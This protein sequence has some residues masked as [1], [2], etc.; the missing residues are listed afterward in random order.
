MPYMAVNIPGLAAVSAP[1]YA[2]SVAA[3]ADQSSAF[4]AGETAPGER[5]SPSAFLKKGKDL[6][7]R[8]AGAFNE[9]SRSR[10]GVDLRAL[11]PKS[12]AAVGVSDAVVAGGMAMSAEGEDEKVSL[13][14]ASTP[15]SPDPAPGPGEKSLF[16]KILGYYFDTPV[17]SMT[18]MGLT[19]FAVLASALHY[20]VS[21]I[22]AH[23]DPSIEPQFV[24]HEAH[25]IAK[26]GAMIVGLATILFGENAFPKFMRPAVR[27]FLRLA[28]FAGPPL[29]F[30]GR[31]LTFG[32]K[33]KSTSDAKADE[34]ARTQ[35]T[36]MERAAEVAS[37]P[38]EMLSFVGET[39]EDPK[40]RDNGFILGAAQEIRRRYDR[41]IFDHPYLGSY[42][43]A[44]LRIWGSELVINGLYVYPLVA[45][46]LGIPFFETVGPALGISL[47]ATLSTSRMTKIW[48]ETA[49]Y[50][51]RIVVGRTAIFSF[52]NTIS[53]L[54]AILLK[55]GTMSAAGGFL[56]QFGL[57][58]AMSLAAL[59]LI[60]PPRDK[61]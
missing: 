41:P 6:A 4:A 32:K 23:S 35:A 46:S 49:E 44:D 19:E 37:L 31:L 61:K 48:G 1:L 50:M 17:L 58:M 18:T 24:V 12:Y 20:G 43:T 8:M 34:N 22:A 15:A 56:I 36:A 51:G 59:G 26:L 11:D 40:I 9:Y 21:L 30:L 27:P 55:T 3:T 54:A 33:A 28:G 45:L 47:A 7:W 10:L 60:R 53:P 38:G 39:L 5:T 13:D 29:R 2:S 52:A 25:K 16:R 42:S 14:D 57:T